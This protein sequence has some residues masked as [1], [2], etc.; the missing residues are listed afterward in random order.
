MGR[1]QAASAVA[2]RQQGTRR[3]LHRAL[4]TNLGEPDHSGLVLRASLGGGAGSQMQTRKGWSEEMGTGSSQAPLLPCTAGQS[5]GRLGVLPTLGLAPHPARSGLRAGLQDL[6]SFR[7]RPPGGFLWLPQHGP[8]LLR[9]CATG[10]HSRHRGTPLAGYRVP[11]NRQTGSPLCIS[12]P[13]GKRGG[14]LTYP[15]PA[16]PPVSPG[17][18]LSY[19]QPQHLGYK[20]RQHPENFPDILAHCPPGNLVTYCGVG[21]EWQ[22]PCF[23]PDS[24]PWDTGAN[25]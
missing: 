7:Q 3:G 1:G 25:G 18:T 9:R 22:P 14:S 8:P 2:G 13:L 5:Q 6:C 12:Q 24:V 23:L 17:P 15:T 10:E 11:R 16:W 21:T 19:P 20:R 4:V